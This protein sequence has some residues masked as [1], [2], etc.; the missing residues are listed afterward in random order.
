MNLA[1]SKDHKLGTV[2]GTDWL[3]CGL[4]SKKFN[5]YAAPKLFSS[6]VGVLSMSFNDAMK[7]TNCPFGTSSEL[8]KALGND[9]YKQG[10]WVIPT[11]DMLRD[12]NIK[13]YPDLKSVWTISKF[14]DEQY[15]FG[16]EQYYWGKKI[17]I[18][19]R[20]ELNQILLVRFEP[21]S[22]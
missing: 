11:V 4:R 18:Q 17:S 20:K 21:V 3:G 6:N 22:V 15:C 19:P 9:T 8:L 13:K 2:N 1:S 12:L 7:A 16:D 5:V 14:M 10:Q